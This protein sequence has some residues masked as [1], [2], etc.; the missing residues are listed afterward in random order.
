MEREN[1]EASLRPNER[2]HKILLSTPAHFVGEFD[3]PDLLLSHAWPPIYTGRGRWTKY[4]EDSLN[5]TALVLAFRTPPPPEPAPGGIVPNYE[6]AGEGVASALSVLFGKRFDSHGPFEMSGSFGL[7]DL[8]AFATPCLPHLRHND[9]KP[10]GDRAIPLNLSEVSRIESLLLGPNQD[11]RFSAFHSAAKFYRRAL[12]TVEIDAESAYLNL[13]TAGEIVSNSQKLTDEATLDSE[14]R[15]VL[16]HIAKEMP[17]GLKTANFL[18]GRLR[19][20]KRR[21]VSAITAMVDDSFFNH[22]EVQS[23]WGALRRSDFEKRLGAA[24]DLRSRF[25]HSGYPFG[26]WITAHMGKFEVQVGRP[27]VPDK[28]MAKVLAMAPLFSGLERVIR[29]VL[30]T[31]AAELG[32]V[33]EV[34]SEAQPEKGVD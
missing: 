24:Y 29:Y 18:R 26:G 2:I 6:G 25:V 27:V 12:A 8:S 7:P 9:G 23:H 17:D 33:V 11:P 19:G 10:R 1:E 3:R 32:A 14:V 34:K 20:I 5:R 13:I 4:G 22:R 16:E 31:L 15:A 28:E 30:L 21:F